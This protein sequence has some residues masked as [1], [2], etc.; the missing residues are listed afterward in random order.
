MVSDLS[1]ANYDVVLYELNSDGRMVEPSNYSDMYMYIDGETINKNVANLNNGSKYYIVVTGNKNGNTLTTKADFEGFSLE[2]KTIPT[3]EECLTQATEITQNQTYNISADE[4]QDVYIS[5]LT[6]AY[7]VKIYKIDIPADY[8][9][10]YEASEYCTYM[11]SGY[12]SEEYNYFN[13]DGIEGGVGG[14]FA[15]RNHNEETK[16]Y[17]IVAMDTSYMKFGSIR[18]QTP[19]DASIFDVDINTVPLDGS[20]D[21]D[22]SMRKKLS[23]SYYGTNM[24]TEGVWF[25]VVVPE[26]DFYS[27]NISYDGSSQYAT[28]VGNQLKYNSESEYFGSYG[29]N[30]LEICYKGETSSINIFGQG[31]YYICLEG[32]EDFFPATIT[33]TKYSESDNP[34]GC[35]HMNTEIRNNK[36]ASCTKEGYSG[37]VYCTACNTLLEKGTV[38]DKLAHTYNQ[39]VI[40]DKTL[41]KAATYDSPAI[42]YYSCSCGAIGTDT[43]TN[44][45]ALVKE[46]PAVNVSYH[47]HIQSLGD[48]Q[49]TKTNG[50]AAGTFGMAKRLE[51]IWIKVDGNENLGIQ[52]T[53]HCQSYGWL[54]WSANGESNGTSGEA[55]RLE[56]IKIQLTGADKDKYDVYY[57]VHA[58]SYGWLGWAK[59]GEPSG[60]AGYGKRLEGIQIVVV[61]KGESAPGLDYADVKASTAVH[62][63]SAYIAKAGTSPVVGG[64]ATSAQNPVI[65]GVDTTNISYRTHVQSYGWQGWKYNG[66]MSGTSGEAKR[67]E[68]IEIKL[69]N[70]Q[71][72]GSIVYTTHVQKYGWQGDVNDSSTW[73]KEGEMAGTSGEA[74]R[75][76]AICIKLT[77]EMEKHYDVYYRV[78][79]QSYGWLG[80]AKN[81]ECAGT[82]G[83]A[84]RLEGIQIVLVPKGGS[85]PASNYGGVNANQ[86]EAYI[87]K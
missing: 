69:T 32:T 77:G 70:K 23:Y 48:S 46:T 81:G 74:K 87:A 11:I 85:A 67:L 73:K 16:T 10:T 27:V 41:K 38:I 59:N 83:Y 64:A 57:R 19:A 36:N 51:N 37:D 26:N 31:D 34:Y 35:E 45:E 18:Q 71:Y 50:Q 43:F 58:Q 40:S 62:N 39:K 79:A 28:W 1:D 66:Q 13:E 3:L 61:K 25:R 24:K 12:Y 65:P 30:V 55:K 9:L 44:G 4:W 47:T 17:Y 56:A 72:S 42:Y 63:T 86:T 78:H 29:Q 14:K 53:T 15:I 22:Y 5:Y 21:I 49:G 75:L 80:W 82:A 7:S 68:G 60:T 52:Y 20:L 6:G 33:V 54:P 84:K 8:E 2:I 76:E